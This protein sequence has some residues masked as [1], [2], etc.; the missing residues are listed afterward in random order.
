[1][2]MKKLVLA[3]AAA[4]GLLSC[5]QNQLTVEG[6]IVGTEVPSKAYLKI[7]DE[8]ETPTIIDSVVIKEGKFAFEVNLENE[9]IGLVALSNDIVFPVVLEKGALKMKADLNNLSGYTIEGTPSNDMYRTFRKKDIQFTAAQE[10][11]YREY[12]DAQLNG[13]LNAAKE[14]EIKARYD[15]KAKSRND[16]V[17][18]CIQ[19]NRSSL[20]SLMVLMQM[21]YDLSKEKLV[22]LVDAIPANFD[23]VGAVR[24]LKKEV[25][26]IKNTAVGQPLIDFT[27]P[28]TEGKNQ[29]LSKLISGSKVVVLDFWA[30]WCGPCR[31]ENPHVVELYKKY[32]D[33][34]LQIVGVSLD[35][36]KE[37]WLEAIKDDTL[38]WIHLSDLNGWKSSAAALYGVKSIPATFILSNGKIV[39]RDLRGAELDKKIEELLVK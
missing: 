33:R 5:T 16:N 10:K 7:I 28:D 14:A 19:Q 6:E 29:V 2:E 11:I 27:L 36:R 1:M 35:T 23:N 26:T 34:G 30:S 3:T 32:K 13:Q 31:S 17:E 15:E 38:N 8:K 22:E 24:A 25:A 18:K 20:V 9:E 21:Q 39:A 4:F 12:V 37:K